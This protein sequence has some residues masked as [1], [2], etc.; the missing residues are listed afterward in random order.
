MSIERDEGFAALQRGDIAAAIA[1]L[2]SAVQQTPDE[3]HAYAY[4]GAAYG[5]AGRHQEAVRVLTRAVELDPANAQARYN[6]GIALESAGWPYE[7]LTAFQQALTLQ[8][9]YTKAQE[10]FAR[11]EAA[12]AAAPVS[13]TVDPLASKTMQLDAAQ[14][15]SYLE[16]TL[17]PGTMY[18]PPVPQSGGASYPPPMPPPAYSAG[19]YTSSY[20]APAYPLHSVF[21]EDRF[22][23]QQALRDWFKV[24]RAPQE[25]F[26]HQAGREGIKAPLAVLLLFLCSFSVVLGGGVFVTARS[27]PEMASF[28]FGGAVVI[29]ALIVLGG[30]IAS[31]LWAGIVHLFGKMF[32]SSAGYAGTFRACTYSQAPYWAVAVTG[33]LLTLVVAGPSLPLLIEQ[34]RAERAAMRASSGSPAARSGPEAG[35]FASA[36]QPEDTPESKVYRT[37]ASEVPAAVEVTLGLFNLAG[38]GAWV[39]AMVLLGIGV[40]HI[41]RVNTGGAVGTVLLSIIVPGLLVFG[42]FVALF[43]SLVGAAMGGSG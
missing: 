4:L 24:I 37:A 36:S 3:Y 9:D 29:I 43:L 39:W 27:V 18:P 11:L 26:A 21:H 5:Q 2:E 8:P 28:A 22:S 7:S 1:Y 40:Y 13:F 14:L 41:Q 35:P 32:G 19:P 10:A 38:F 16:P 6:L 17:Q 31:F 20:S 30:L 33:M 23:I 15:P 12:Q 25:F 34:R 42:F